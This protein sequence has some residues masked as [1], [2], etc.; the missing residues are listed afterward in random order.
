M[1]LLA[2][3]EVMVSFLF[4]VARVNGFIHLS[5]QSCS[6]KVLH[7]LRCFNQQHVANTRLFWFRNVFNQ[8]CHLQ[9][10]FCCLGFGDFLAFK[11]YSDLLTHQTN[12]LQSLLLFSYLHSLEQPSTPS[13]SSQYRLSV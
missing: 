2:L 13:S 5:V 11:D 7:V 12:I 9:A 10:L 1:R 4:Q 6:R 3:L 8:R